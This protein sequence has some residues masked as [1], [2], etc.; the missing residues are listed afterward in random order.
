MAS[1]EWIVESGPPGR[2][3][4]D[5]RGGAPGTSPEDWVPPSV[6]PGPTTSFAE[7]ARRVETQLREVESR[8]DQ[9]VDRAERA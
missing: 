6:A 1:S 7:R 3:Q 9:A 2:E 8:L 5:H 4:A